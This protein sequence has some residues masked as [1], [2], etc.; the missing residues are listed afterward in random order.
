MDKVFYKRFYRVNAFVR[1]VFLHRRPGSE[2][3]LKFSE[4]PTK[5]KLE[6]RRFHFIK[7]KRQ[8]AIVV[9]DE[10]SLAVPIGSDHCR[11]K[12]VQMR[13]YFRNDIEQPVSPHSQ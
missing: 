6:R 3:P 9:V 4:C 11:I 12:T 1:L 5:R 10:L 8:R 7:W 13:I 2:I